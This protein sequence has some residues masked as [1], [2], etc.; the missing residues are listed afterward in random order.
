MAATRGEAGPPG[1]DT[2]PRRAE[3]DDVPTLIGLRV[4]AAEW[5]RSIGSDQWHDTARASR[6]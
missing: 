6:T 2:I 5:L 1:L 4:A 3:P